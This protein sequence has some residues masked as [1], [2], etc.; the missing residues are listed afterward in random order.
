MDHR[1]RGGMDYRRPWRRARYGRRR[2]RATSH[3][4]TSHEFVPKHQFF[5]DG[6]PIRCFC[7]NGCLRR[8]RRA[9]ARV[10]I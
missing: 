9:L 2:H 5:D 10:I 4:P 7:S 1:R 6:P 3:K 8:N